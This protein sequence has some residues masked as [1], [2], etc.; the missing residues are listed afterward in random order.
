MKLSA[1]ASEMRADTITSVWNKWALGKY[2]TNKDDSEH[3]D[4]RYHPSMLFRCPAYIFLYME[5]FP[6]AEDWKPEKQ[7][8][9]GNGD[10]VHERIQVDLCRAGVLDVSMFD[11]TQ[12]TPISI[13]E[14]K[15]GGHTDGVLNFGPKEDTGKT[16]NFF[17]NECPCYKFL[18]PSQRRIL[19]IK[20]INT[21]G[22]SKLTG[23]KAEHVS[24]A[25]I[26]G[27]ALGINKIHF[28]Y[29]DK[30]NQQWKEYV[31]IVDEEAVGEAKRTA[32]L[33]EEWRREFAK[34]NKIPD[35]VIAQARATAKRKDL[36]PWEVYAIRLLMPRV[37]ARN[38]IKQWLRDREAHY[39]NNNKPRAKK[40]RTI[41]R[42]K[43]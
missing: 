18:D 19:E 24:Q 32:L 42:S 43:K 26:Y 4:G 30:N 38:V 17:G 11:D 10:G 34:T 36:P 9:F 13:P 2:V 39:A 21:M 12:E 29:E 16:F 35:A 28:L 1:R 3:N 37:G 31:T 33:V 14:Y 23:A 27:A 40:K 6:I 15:I 25:S 7:R 5:Q 22:F 41:V 20:S 8:V